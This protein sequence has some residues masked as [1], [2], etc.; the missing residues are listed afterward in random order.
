MWKSRRA[1]SKGCG[2]RRETRFWFSSFST[3]RH[4]HGAP[5]FS[6]AFSLLAESEEELPL[7][8]LHL[9]RRLGIALPFRDLVQSC[10]AD[11][12]FEVARRF[13]RGGAQLPQ[14]FP[15]CG[16]TPVYIFL[17][18]VLVHDPLRL[19]ARSVEIQIRIEVASVE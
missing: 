12:F 15:G 14:C 9:S 5:R 18:A 3:A 11:F 17:F 4:F 13:R 7:G 10:N 6:C 16:V 2:T 19:S 1:I 8:V